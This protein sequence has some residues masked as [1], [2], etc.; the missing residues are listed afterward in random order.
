M[1]ELDVK[2]GA[3]KAVEVF[4]VQELSGLQDIPFDSMS[5][6]RTRVLNPWPNLCPHIKERKQVLAG[7]LE[8]TRA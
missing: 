5:H 1:K 4:W 8:S 6:Y 2:T 3:G 7:C